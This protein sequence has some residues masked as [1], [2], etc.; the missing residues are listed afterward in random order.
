M[1]SAS[2]NLPCREGL[3][4]S[5]QETPHLGDVLRKREEKKKRKTE[6]EEE[7]E[8]GEGKEAEGRRAWERKRER[9]RENLC[10]HQCGGSGVVN[11]E[12]DGPYGLNL[13]SGSL[14]EK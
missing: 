8:G 9:K 10:G 1:T 13:V 14:N 7:K 5:H 11:R 4:Y 2:L 3:P 6:R 12:M